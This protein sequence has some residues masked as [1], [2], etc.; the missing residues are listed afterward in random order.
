MGEE[1]AF[2]GSFKGWKAEEKGGITQQ[3]LKF[4]IEKRLK[5]GKNKRRKFASMF[6]N[7]GCQEKQ[8]RKNL[9]TNGVTNLLFTLVRQMFCF[10]VG[11]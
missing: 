10:S 11:S 8:R 2:D 5:D 1:R 7:E 6:R 3:C 9:K 4:T